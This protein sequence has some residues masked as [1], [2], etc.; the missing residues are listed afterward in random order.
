MD[1]P[2][3]TAAHLT[4][5]LRVWPERW[6]NGQ[7]RWRGEVLHPASGERRPFLDLHAVAEFIHRWTGEPVL[8]PSPADELVS[9]SPN[10]QP[11]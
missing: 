7:V 6:L 1:T 10:S 3:A 2:Q 5:V 4:F 8:G 9:P 11:L